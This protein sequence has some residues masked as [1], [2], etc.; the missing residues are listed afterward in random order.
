MLTA[1]PYTYCHQERRVKMTLTSK[2]HYDLMQMF[3]KEFSGDFRLDREDK[4]M[5]TKGRVYQSDDA[6]LAFKAFRSGAA[7][8]IAISEN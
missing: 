4:G 6:N 7:Y 1:M 5:W 8:G 3:E 2:D